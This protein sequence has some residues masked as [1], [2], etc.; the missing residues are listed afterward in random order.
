MAVLDAVE[1]CSWTVS[2]VDEIPFNRKQIAYMPSAHWRLWQRL[3]MFSFFICLFVFVALRLF[4]LL[5]GKW[6]HV[7]N[8]ADLNKQRNE[9]CVWPYDMK[10]MHGTQTKTKQ[11]NEKNK[12][13]IFRSLTRYTN[14]HTRNWVFV[15]GNWNWRRCIV[16]IMKVASTFLSRSLIIIRKL[17]SLY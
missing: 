8:T 7:E 15:F 11:N 4:F 3:I 1:Y 2:S 9:V 5:L 16:Q 13:K 6:V 17:G 10:T 12:I 14:K